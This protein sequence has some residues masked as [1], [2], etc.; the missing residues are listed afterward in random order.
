M[1]NLWDLV[2]RLRSNHSKRRANEKNNAQS[3]DARRKSLSFSGN[4]PNTWR[5]ESS[6]SWPPNEADYG[7][8]KLVRDTESE[9]EMWTS[10]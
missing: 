1:M 6:E 5:Q 2:K 8:V 9:W 3:S 4:I 10:W 7:R